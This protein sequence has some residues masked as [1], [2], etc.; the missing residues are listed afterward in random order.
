MIFPVV[1]RINMKQRYSG[2]VLEERFR[3]YGLELAEEKTGILE[4]ASFVR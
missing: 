1:S 4:F 2:R 3:K